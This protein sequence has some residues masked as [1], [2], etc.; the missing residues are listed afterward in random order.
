MSVGYKFGKL[1]VHKSKLLRPSDQNSASN[2]HNIEGQECLVTAQDQTL[3]EWLT[4]A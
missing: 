3:K 2:I 4:W 1:K